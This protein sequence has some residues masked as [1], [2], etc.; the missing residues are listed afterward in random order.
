MLGA[1]PTGALSG[2]H[3]T[4]EVITQAQGKMAPSWKMAKNF[5]MVA[6]RHWMDPGLS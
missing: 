3:R 1:L 6:A 5:R 4:E 2:G